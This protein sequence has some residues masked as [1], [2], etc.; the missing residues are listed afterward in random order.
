MM[1]Y[2]H[3]LCERTPLHQVN[4]S[5]TLNI[6]IFNFLVWEHVSSNFLANFSYTIVLPTI[7]MLYIRSSEPY[8][9]TESLYLLPTY[10][11]P[12]PWQSPIYSVSMNLTF[13]KNISYYY[14]YYYHQFLDSTCKLCHAV[15]VSLCLLSLTIYHLSG[16]I[17]LTIM[18][19][20]LFRIYFS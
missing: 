13:Q 19:S 7:V 10:P 14:Y 6:H 15:F 11:F 18:P 9:I 5:I 16:H 17:S 8:H 1:I 4:T 12:L 3:I 20:L 2:I